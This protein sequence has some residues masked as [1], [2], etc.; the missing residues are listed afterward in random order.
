MA[1]K[2]DEPTATG[3]DGVEDAKGLATVCAH[4]H[5]LV[6]DRAWIHRRVD[7]MSFT[8]GLMVR[9]WTSID[10]TVP[11]DV[12]PFGKIDGQSAFYLPVTILAK[13]PPV[14]RF[15]LRD[16]KGRPIPLLTSTKNREVDAAVLSALA[17][18]YPP[19]LKVRELLREVAQGDRAKAALALNNL[20]TV[21]ESSVQ[22]EEMPEAA[23]HEWARLK[24][25]LQ[26]LVENSLLW[27]RVQ[28]EPGTRRIVKY[29]FEQPVEKPLF[30]FRSALGALS[31]RET[32]NV[33]AIPRVDWAQNY[34]L[35]I[36]APPGLLLHDAQ[37][38]PSVPHEGDAPGARARLPRPTPTELLQGALQVLGRAGVE[39]RGLVRETLEASRQRLAKIGRL[40]AEADPGIAGRPMRE[41]FVEPQTGV[42]WEWKHRRRAY[43]YVSRPHSTFAAAKF[44][45]IAPYSSVRGPLAAAVLLAALMTVITVRAGAVAMHD[46]EAVT[47]LV[48]VPVVIGALVFRPGE[49]PLV[50]RH[51][52][53]VRL[54]LI[55]AG[56]APVLAAIVL[57]TRT[58][59]S[60]GDL[61]PFFIPLTVSA[62]VASAGL[63]LSV[64]LP[65]QGYART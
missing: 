65:A 5:R 29:G 14:M 56:A 16:E 30:F 41:Q 9:V 49:H 58:H 11:R 34:H 45:F 2:E 24:Q 61:L 28:G 47:A 33:Y 38:V 7:A 55:V 13:W 40:A 39:M 20:V 19:N 25:L 18:A 23:R 35:Q 12:I 60:A 42:S 8:E 36:D 32:S 52:V 53:G 17:P 31:W 1:D 10:F 62:W 44:S 57:L 46:G 43:L 37:L 51:I 4:N 27:V 59:P 22:S 50:R 15:D 63:G 64:L 48:V 3:V 6:I 54:L 21:L 26:P